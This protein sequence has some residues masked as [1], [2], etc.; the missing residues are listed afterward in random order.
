[1]PFDEILAQRLRN[2]FRNK[3]N[4]EEKKMFGGLCFMKSNHMCCGIVGD[5]LVVRVGPDNYQHCLRRQY[6]REMDFT[7]KAM[8]GMVYVDA[9]GLLSDTVLSGWIKIATDFVE[10]LPAKKPAKRIKPKKAIKH[11]RCLV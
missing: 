6:A 7:G 3:D 5:K 2:I 4:I 8:K 1:M 9:K 11:S 10:T